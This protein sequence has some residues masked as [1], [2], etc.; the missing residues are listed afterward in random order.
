MYCVSL[1]VCFFYFTFLSFIL[2]V[3]SY[4][5]I[6]CLPSF[7]IFSPHIFFPLP[8]P[9]HLW[10]LIFVIP[11]CICVAGTTS[12]GQSSECTASMELAPA[13]STTLSPSTRTLVRPSC[14]SL[15]CKAWCLREGQEAVASREGDEEGRGRGEEGMSG[16]WRGWWY[17]LCEWRCWCWW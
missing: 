5:F 14:T 8:P 11:V 13:F 12:E 7:L 16:G 17:Q 3:I 9:S 6:S 4:I 10:F 2:S 1:V 15:T